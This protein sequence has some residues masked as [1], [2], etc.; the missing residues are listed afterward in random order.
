MK[1]TIYK[2]ILLAFV[3]VL[4]APC[5]GIASETPSEEIKKSA[6]E[7]IHSHIKNRKIDQGIRNLGL[8]SQTEIDNAEIGD[9]FQIFTIHSGDLL[10]E[11]NKDFQSLV[12]PT[13]QWELLVVVDGNAKMIMRVNYVNGKWIHGA[14]GASTFAKEL[15]G[16]LATWPVS[17]DYQCRLIRIYQ[18]SYDFI[19]I[20]KKGQLIGIL[21]L[22]SLIRIPERVVGEFKPS[23]LRDPKEILSN[24]RTVVKQHIENWNEM[25]KK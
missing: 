3:V 9:G 18:G 4:S 17:S 10:D 22:S 8:E 20:S 16:V 12:T 1:I 25:K 19:E 2:F 24:L 21:P 23:D 5:L 6:M 7:G 13:D 11:H 14:I 15:S